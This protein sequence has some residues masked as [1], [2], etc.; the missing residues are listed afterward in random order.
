[1]FTCDVPQTLFVINSAAVSL[2]RISPTYASVISGDL[3]TQP[4]LPSHPLPSPPL[5]P[6][7]FPS[8]SSAHSFLFSFHSAS[9]YRSRQ[10]RDAPAS[11]PSYNDH[12]QPSS[13]CNHRCSA[14]TDALQCNHRC[15]AT[16]TTTAAGHRSGHSRRCHRTIAF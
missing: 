8:T 15:P 10:T 14:T 6:I 5:H 7:P 4:L 12:W 13:P 16:I 9:L 3:S 1:M 11:T 2:K